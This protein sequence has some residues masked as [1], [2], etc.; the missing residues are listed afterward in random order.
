MIKKR[1]KQHIVKLKRRVIFGHDST[2][3]KIK[4][5]NM[6]VAMVTERAVTP[7]CDFKILK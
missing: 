3:T 4:F 7:P 6:I 2:K 5:P 1:S